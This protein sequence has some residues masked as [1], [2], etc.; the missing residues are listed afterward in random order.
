V[1]HV[2]D[3]F[4]QKALATLL[5]DAVHAL[6]L[7]Q[8]VTASFLIGSPSE[9]AP[10]WNARGLQIALWLHHTEG[11][12]FPTSYGRLPGVR[13]LHICPRSCRSLI[14]HLVGHKSEAVSKT[15][16][17]DLL[18]WVLYILIAL[19]NSIRGHVTTRST[20]LP[21]VSKLL[22]IWAAQY[23]IDTAS[24]YPPEI[25]THLDATCQ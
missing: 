10:R 5:V 24:S 11:T 23:T 13:Q 16:R 14:E 3:T 18:E 4:E 19:R 2:R 7:S 1:H 25:P 15:A 22:Q 8:F 21:Y 12:F 9:L 20:C 6:S 17:P